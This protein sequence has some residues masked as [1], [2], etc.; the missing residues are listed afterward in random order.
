MPANLFKIIIEDDGQGIRPD[1]VTKIKD[2]YYSSRPGTKRRVG[3]GL[4]LM[5]ATCQR[6]DG[7]LDIE[8]EYRYGTTVTAIMEHDNIDR[9]PL[10]DLPDMVSSLMISSTE[11]RVIWTIEHIFNGEGYILRNRMTADELNIFSYGEPGVKEKLQALISN[12]EAGI[13]RSAYEGL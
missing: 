7:S 11:N 12:K 13:G 5:D 4:S 10:G 6:C 3:L 8:S 1:Q 2:P 9:P